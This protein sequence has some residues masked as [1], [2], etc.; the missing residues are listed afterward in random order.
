MKNFKTVF[1]K[2]KIMNQFSYIVDNT[3]IR[4]EGFAV[5]G[6]LHSGITETI[7]LILKASQST[8][9]K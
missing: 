3:R 9:E 2:H 4:K 1:V 5:K 6:D 7:K 8:K